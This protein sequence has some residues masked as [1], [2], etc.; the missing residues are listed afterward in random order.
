MGLLLVFSLVRMVQW[1]GRAKRPELI[2]A[3]DHLLV[4][5]TVVAITMMTGLSLWSSWSFVTGL[6]SHVVLIPVSLCFGVT[7]VAHCL[8]PLRTAAT[9]ALICGIVPVGLTMAAGG[10]FENQ[11]LGL[12]MLSIAA[13]MVR[14][15]SEQHDQLVKSL[16][17]EHR[18]TEQANTDPLTGLANRR[19]V[20]ARL[21]A[22]VASGKPFALALL[23][24][25]GFKQVNDTF[26]H[27]VGDALLVVVADR[28]KAASPESNLVG[29]L[30]G[31][32]FIVLM[33]GASTR[34]TAGQ[35]TSALLAELAR[36]VTINGHA[37][38]FGA[39]LGFAVVGI[40][41]TTAEKL[42]TVADEALYAVKRERKAAAGRVSIAA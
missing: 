31:D 39:S 38:T 36:P 22:D 5:M 34:E 19:A 21:E 14:F 35:R 41:G 6:F 33:R 18:I 30:G 29:R 42:L 24:L 7:C 25:D 3:P 11:M 1:M 4:R 40:D 13:L 9:G 20:M 8:A 12:S 2:A 23:D 17:L 27:Q 26:G 10:A 32:E 37:I 28:L 15:V 16:V